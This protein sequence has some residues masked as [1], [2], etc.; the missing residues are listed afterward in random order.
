M[1][2]TSPGSGMSLKRINLTWVMTMFP[3]RSY[4]YGAMRGS[5]TFHHLSTRLRNVESSER[6]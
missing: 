1:N 6:S 5:S 3:P 4:K 2:A